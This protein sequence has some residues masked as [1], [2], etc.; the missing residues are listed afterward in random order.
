MRAT[1]A[2]LAGQAL[3]RHHDHPKP[4]GKNTENTSETK[5]R[6][7][8]NQKPLKQKQK[9]KVCWLFLGVFNS[10]AAKPRITPAV[11]FIRLNE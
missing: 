2:R 9:A 1:G 11:H 3:E 10:H 5:I 7:T 6:K 4:R 8:H